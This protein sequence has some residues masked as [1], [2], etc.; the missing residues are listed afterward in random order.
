MQQKTLL[1]PEQATYWL[2]SDIAMAFMPLLQKLT[3]DTDH[4]T[5]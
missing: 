5:S 1:Y 2:P 3:Q 4:R